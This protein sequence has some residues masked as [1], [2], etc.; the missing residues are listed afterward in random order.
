MHNQRKD[1]SNM[2]FRQ[3][4]RKPEIG[5][6]SRIYCQGTVI[7]EAQFSGRCAQEQLKPRAITLNERKSPYQ[8]RITGLRATLDPLKSSYPR[9]GQQETSETSG[10]PQ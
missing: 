8:D 10:S 6:K 9:R 3:R 4:E 7:Q 5:K 1:E 2:E